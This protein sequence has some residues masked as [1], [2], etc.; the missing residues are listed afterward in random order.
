MSL[1]FP[2]FNVILKNKSGR[3]KKREMNAE[4]TVPIATPGRVA[5][6]I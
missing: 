1:S 5:V 2:F 4:Q 3:L 6:E